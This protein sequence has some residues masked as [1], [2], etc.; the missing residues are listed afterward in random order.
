MHLRITND[1]LVRES[2]S[3]TRL[4]SHHLESGRLADADVQN[5]PNDRPAEGGEAKLLVDGSLMWV[6][7]GRATLSVL[8]HQ[9]YICVQALLEV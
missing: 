2:D 4:A 1:N 6:Q 5:E 3:V 9:Y 7:L 8:Y